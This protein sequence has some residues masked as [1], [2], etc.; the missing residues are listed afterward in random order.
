MYVRVSQG[1][2][3]PS[4]GSEVHAIGEASAKVLAELPGFSRFISAV[5]GTSG[6]FAVIT[7]WESEQA[8]HFD[9]SVIASIMQRMSANGMALLAP[10]VFEVDVDQGR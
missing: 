8:A 10:Q 7:F 2:F 5:D 6:T 3:D 4:I 9:R 1:T